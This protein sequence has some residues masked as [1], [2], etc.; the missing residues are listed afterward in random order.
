MDKAVLSVPTAEAPR[1]TVNCSE[2]ELTENIARLVAK[3]DSRIKGGRN[4]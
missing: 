1:G 3:T 2:E 4:E